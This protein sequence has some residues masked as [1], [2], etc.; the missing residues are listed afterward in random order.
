MVSGAD[1]R[2]SRLGPGAPL[3]LLR[4]ARA[5]GGGGGESRRYRGRAP[6]PRPASAPARAWPG[7]AAWSSVRGPAPAPA[8][9]SAS[10]PPARWS[11][12]AASSGDGAVSLQRAVLGLARSGLGAASSGSFLWIVTRAAD[13]RYARW[14]VTGTAGGSDAPPMR[15]LAAGPGKTGGPGGGRRGPRRRPYGAGSVRPGPAGRVVGG[16]VGAVR[17]S[18]TD[19][20]AASL[21]RMGPCEWPAGAWATAGGAATE[22]RSVQVQEACAVG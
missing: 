5:A 18:G 17:S 20:G 8:A 22:R 16:S 2:R 6:R 10:R 3:A 12:E 9:G 14:G 11:L 21:L 1:G 7:H 19:A 13:F 15:G 4:G